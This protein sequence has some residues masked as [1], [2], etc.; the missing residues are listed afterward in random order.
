MIQYR[1]VQHSFRS[2]LQEKHMFVYH[3]ISAKT[4][5]AKAHLAICRKEG[6][7]RE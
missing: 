1:Y 4:L 6:D 5:N 2:K 3:H 7:H